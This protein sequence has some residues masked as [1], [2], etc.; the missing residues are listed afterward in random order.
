MIAAAEA[1]GGANRLTNV[2]INQESS[3]QPTLILN[4]LIKT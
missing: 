3:L 1:T 4:Y 2:M